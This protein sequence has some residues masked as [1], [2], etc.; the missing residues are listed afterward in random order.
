LLKLSPLPTAV[1]AANDL[2][3][4]GAM[5]A[6][7]EANLRIP[8]DIALVGLDDIPAAKLVHPALT[9]SSQLQEDIGRRAAEMLFERIQGTVIDEPR[10]VEMP[11]KLIVRE[12]A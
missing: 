10:S 6:I 1:F 4:L 5:S 9:T 2:M 7:R 11:F 12:S 8:E 3:A